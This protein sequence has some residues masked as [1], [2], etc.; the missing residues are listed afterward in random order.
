MTRRFG[1]VVESWSVAAISAVAMLALGA[2]AAAAA[3]PAAASQSEARQAPYLNGGVGQ[4]SQDKMKSEAAQ[5]PL[6]LTFSAKA[7]NDYVADVQLAIHDHQGAE[8]LKLKDAGPITYV[9]LP[10]GSYRISAN[11]DGKEKVRSV[12]VGR[13]SAVNFHWDE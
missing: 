3:S 2:P 7:D 5:W 10:P 11:H 1:R 8:V 13:S 12:D 9:R 4:G 6:H